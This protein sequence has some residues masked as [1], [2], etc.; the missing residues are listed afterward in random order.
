MSLPLFLSSFLPFLSFSFFLS[1][2]FF[3][4]FLSPFLPSYSFFLS[5]Y[6][7]I[8]PSIHLRAYS[9]AHFKQLQLS[10][11][12][13]GDWNGE[14]GAELRSE[15]ASIQNWN[16]GVR[17]LFSNP[18]ILKTEYSRIGWIK[19]FKLGATLISLSSFC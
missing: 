16:A 1:F 2:F 5:F 17:V 13:K 7:S 3:F 9:S 15:A 14:E 11:L 19:C 6:L 8:Y 4:L 12:L 18:G 10:S